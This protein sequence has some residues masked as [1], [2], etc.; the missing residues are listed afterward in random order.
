VKLIRVILALIA[1]TLNVLAVQ[2]F[3]QRSDI[4][5]NIVV[6]YSY[7]ETVTTYVN[8][9]YDTMTDFWLYKPLSDPQVWE[10]SGAT[11][12]KD[13]VGQIDPRSVNPAGDSWQTSTETRLAGSQ[14]TG[15]ITFKVSQPVTGGS[16][17]SIAYVTYI[18]PS[19][20]PSQF[21]YIPSTSY[22]PR[23]RV[24]GLTL[25]SEISDNIRTDTLCT[26][27]VVKVNPTKYK[28][29][30]TAV[31]SVLRINLVGVDP[32]GGQSPAVISSVTVSWTSNY[33]VVAFPITN[34]Y[35]RYYFFTFDE[36][37]YPSNPAP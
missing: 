3:I 24:V 29:V 14:S 1:L 32:I 30:S 31:P 13:T 33:Q 9:S 28:P 37:L 34:R 26:N 19:A 22:F 7:H 36:V 15:T 11:V 20:S 5:D 2:Q 25:L 6:V 23:P 4:S 17:E 21:G 8:G 18:S 35:P 27:L 12:L 16:I 10:R